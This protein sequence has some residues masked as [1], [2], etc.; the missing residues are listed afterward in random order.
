MTHLTGCIIQPKTKTLWRTFVDT[1]TNEIIRFVDYLR[2]GMAPLSDFLMVYVNPIT[3]SM[4]EIPL[5]IWY[6][7][8]RK[9]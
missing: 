8:N 7:N 1:K 9:D 2:G 3:K 5:N 6:E 4:E